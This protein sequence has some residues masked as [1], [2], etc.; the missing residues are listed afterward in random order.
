MNSFESCSELW[1]RAL[2]AQQTRYHPFIKRWYDL[3]K[4]YNPFSAL[5]RNKKE[6]LGLFGLG[7]LGR[8]LFEDLADMGITPLWIV[9]NQ[10]ELAGGRHR[11]VLVIEEKVLWRVP[12]LNF[13]IITPIFD[14]AVIS[15]RIHQ[16]NSG[17]ETVSLETLVTGV[18]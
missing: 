3:K 5:S 18:E 6:A 16:L 2:A 14:V 8:L 7:T 4:S 11:G 13:L 15:D 10:V 12:E 1:R 17:L 9:D